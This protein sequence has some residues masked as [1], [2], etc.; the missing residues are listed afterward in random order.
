MAVIEKD[1]GEDFLFFPAEIQYKIIPDLLWAGEQIA[2]PDLAV[3][4]L[5][6]K[7]DDLAGMDGGGELVITRRVG[8]LLCCCHG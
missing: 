8:D 7:L 2:P 6:G 1:T 4:N 3:Q 5:K